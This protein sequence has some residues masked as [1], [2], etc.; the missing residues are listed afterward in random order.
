MQSRTLSIQQS[1][2]HVTDARRAHDISSSRPV[3]RRVNTDPRPILSP[4]FGG[5]S[6]QHASS[7]AS[8]V[9][10]PDERNDRHDILYESTVTSAVSVHQTRTEQDL[11][12]R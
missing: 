10:R 12:P 9:M 5:T 3:I 4:D 2:G 8:P 6:H 7:H 11:H 1:A